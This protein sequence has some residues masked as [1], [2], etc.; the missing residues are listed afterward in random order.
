MSRLLGRLAAALAAMIVANSAGEALPGPETGNTGAEEPVVWE[1]IDVSGLP[2]LTPETYPLVDGSTATLPI[3]YALYR[4]C[5][6]AGEEEAEQAITHTKTDYA[7]YGLSSDMEEEYATRLVIAYEPSAEIREYLDEYAGAL[8]FMPIGK[9]ALVFLANTGNPVENL[10]EDQLIDIYTGKIRNWS[11]LGGSNLEILAFQRSANSGSQTLMENLVLK[12]TEPMP[13]PSYMVPSEMG[14]LIEK[15]SG[16]SNE[17]NALGY[18]VYFYARNMYS[19]PNLRFMAVNGVEPDNKTIQSGEYP[20]TNDFYA[21]IREEEP[22]DSPA[23]QI[24]EWLVS[25]PGQELIAALGYVPVSDSVAA[26]GEEAPVYT[27][28]AFERGSASYELEDGE[29]ILV[30]GDD[31]LNHSGL[32]ALDGEMNEIAVWDDLYMKEDVLVQSLDDPVMAVSREAGAMGVYCPETG[33]WLIPPVYSSVSY[34][35]D[36]DCYRAY[37]Y[38]YETRERDTALLVDGKLIA[39]HGIYDDEEAGFG[40]IW[41]FGD[42]I[43]IE[44]K[45]NV[46]SIVDRKGNLIRTMDLEAVKEQLDEM[47]AAA[48]EEPPAELPEIDYWYF[49]QSYIAA[50]NEDDTGM[51]FDSEGNLMIL[52]SEI[53]GAIRESF[54]VDVTREHNG[55]SY[56]AAADTPDG[57]L[58]AG[59]IFAENDKDS[60][61]FL[62]NAGTGEMLS[63]KGDE[64]NIYNEGA[65]S[66][67]SFSVWPK[68]AGCSSPDAR[69]YCGSDKPLEASDGTRFTCTLGNGYYAYWKEGTLVIED[70]EGTVH[71]EYAREDAPE[72]QWELGSVAGR[73]LFILRNQEDD[74]MSLWHGEELLET[75]E[76]IFERFSMYSGERSSDIDYVVIQSSDSGNR[77]YDSRTGEEI[78]RTNENEYVSVMHTPVLLTIRDYYCYFRTV[79]GELVLKVRREVSNSD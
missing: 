65:G 12:G 14:E 25:E 70:K 16:Y 74:T 44:E 3:S 56:N 69:V 40:N 38:D 39:T 13:A 4:I 78:L 68:D 61:S 24:A 67:V 35:G 73:D 26:A 42:R 76:Y 8:D 19:M 10:S 7:F 34:D 6:G 17:E 58:I 31:Y 64:V 53:E 37:R 55:F 23:R 2:E 20:Y 29:V 41:V 75:A 62:Y 79:D 27:A 71:Y 28:L 52:P 11:E 48:G 22:E 77:I 9:D 5:T 47:A 33:E 36:I 30:N 57:L 51:I 45:K 50:V 66:P 1:N 54:G 60:G 32:T 43:W 46:F 15:V 63:A 72:N 59:Y 18:S 49:S 21:V